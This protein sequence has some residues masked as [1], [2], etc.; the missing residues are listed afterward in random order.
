MPLL[1]VEAG[2]LGQSVQAG[3]MPA[4]LLCCYFTSPVPC[5]HCASVW[6]LL[7]ALVFYLGE[8]STIFFDAL[9]LEPGLTKKGLELPSSEVKKNGPTRAATGR[10]L[11]L[12]L[13]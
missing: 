1:R 8:H 9:F 12:L 7:W 13:L 2:G 3:S 5:F 11:L 6:T 4:S 10:L